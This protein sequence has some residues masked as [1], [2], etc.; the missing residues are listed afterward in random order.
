LVLWLPLSDDEAAPG[1]GRSTVSFRKRCI[2]PSGDITMPVVPS[3]HGVSFSLST[4]CPALLRRASSL[5]GAGRV[6]Q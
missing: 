2:D 1:A 4:T 5:T 6:M 3:R